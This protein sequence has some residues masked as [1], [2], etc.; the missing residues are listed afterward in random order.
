MM[1]TPKIGRYELQREIG[2]GGMAVVYLGR[3][4]GNSRA[5]AIK[6]LP[7][8]FVFDPKFR[9]R[10][11]REAKVI[12]SL[13]SPGI[14]PVYD[15]GE[16]EGQPYMV[17]R[18]MAGG[19]LRQRISDNRSSLAETASIF[20][21]IA[22]AL[23]MAHR[24]GL[25]HRD[26]K[27]DNV[28]FDEDNLAYLSDFGIVKMTEGQSMTLTTHG[29]VL[30]T[31]AFMSPE[32]VIGK[33]KLDGRS[34]VYALGVILYQMLTGRLPYQSDT[35]MS[36]AMMHVLEPLPNIL[37]LR[38]DLPEKIQSIIEKAMAKDREDR[39]PTAMAL[40]TAVRE[41]AELVGEMPATLV[42]VKEG[43]KRSPMTI[44]LGGLFALLCLVIG[45]GA[46]YLVASGQDDAAT[47]TPSPEQATNTREAVFEPL[48]TTGPPST[49]AFILPDGTT[50][51]GSNEID[52]DGAE[53]LIPTLKAT[54]SEIEPTATVTKRIPP[55][56]RPS[57]TPEPP[58]QPTSA[59]PPP[60]P[61]NTPQPPP[62]NTPQPLP[63]DTSQ[64]PTSEPTMEPPPTNTPH[65]PTSEPT[66]EIPTVQPTPTESD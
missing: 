54:R 28:L 59:P 24:L 33:E 22:P 58:P 21:Q 60:P 25:V 12:T 34:D 11:Q 39:Y 51:T 40:A 42:P 35:P 3:D 17:M 45:A 23:D 6:L 9:A 26:I 38:P 65:P 53:G 31:P 19:S 46:V 14:V 15:F 48:E 43:G 4:P 7:R 30:G 47:S 52:S 5:V 29:G 8:E 20:G 44:L 55:T 56:A 49:A 41:L 32:Q 10:F 16:H 50:P 57:D 1:S 62:T 61:T 66:V 27:P 63:T 36:Q 18:Y 37:E 64:P 2:R 13:Q